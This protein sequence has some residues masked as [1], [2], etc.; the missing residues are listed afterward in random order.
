MLED[1]WRSNRRNISCIPSGTY[2]VEPHGWDP[3]TTV[4]FKQTGRLLDVPGRSGS[5]IHAGNTHLNTEGCL[6]VGMGLSVSQ[7]LSSVNDSQIAISRLR[8]EI[9]QRGFNLTIIDAIH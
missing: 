9:G 5:L 7:L 8:K 3:A 2:R 4:K 1:M 6:L